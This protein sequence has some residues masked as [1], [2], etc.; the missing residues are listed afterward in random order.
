MQGRDPMVPYGATDAGVEDIQG[1]IWL[2]GMNCEINWYAKLA[3]V[4]EHKTK[5]PIE[6]SE[7]VLNEC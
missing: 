3:G 5:F 4:E 7:L 6:I 1:N 2:W